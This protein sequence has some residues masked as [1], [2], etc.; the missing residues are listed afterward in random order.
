MHNE[1]SYKDPALGALCSF[2]WWKRNSSQEERMKTWMTPAK[3]GQPGNSVESILTFNLAAISQAFDAFFLRGEQTVSIALTVLS[4]RVCQFFSSFPSESRYR[5]QRFFYPCLHH[6]ANKCSFLSKA[7]LLH[8]SCFFRS[9]LF[10]LIFL[11][12]AYGETCV[13]AGTVS[14]T[15]AKCKGSSEVK[16]M[17]LDL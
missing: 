4:S 9:H 12:E 3:A 1:V 7:S 16:G 2:A 11:F 8:I 17:I 13:G 14:C 6:L 5:W 10:L 15:T